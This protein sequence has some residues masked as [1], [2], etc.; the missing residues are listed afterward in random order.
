VLVL[1]IYFV[2]RLAIMLLRISLD[3]GLV[4]MLMILGKFNIL[5]VLNLS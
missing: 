5:S 2:P 4:K 1:G 3:V